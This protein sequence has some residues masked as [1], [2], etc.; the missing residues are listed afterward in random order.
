MCLTGSVLVSRSNMNNVS[1]IELVMQPTRQQQEPL[2][3]F[4]VAERMRKETNI[5]SFS[6]ITGEQVHNYPVIYT[7][8]VAGL[9]QQTMTHTHSTAMH[10]ERYTE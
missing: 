3:F 7:L 5:C 2:H 1:L 4:T 10:I 9:G 8:A 6:F